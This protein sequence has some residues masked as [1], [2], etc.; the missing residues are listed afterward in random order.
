MAVFPKGSATGGKRIWRSPASQARRRWLIAGVIL[1]VIILLWYIYAHRTQQFPGPTNDPLRL[2]GIIAFVLV[3]ATA[4][5]S[6]RR[7]FVRNLPG[8]VQSWLWM[9]T[10]IGI[11]TILIAVLHEDFVRITHDY[12]EN[13]TCLTDTYYATSALFGLIFLV[14]SG[15]VGRLLDVWQTRVI[16][17]EA[18]SN[19]VGIA[20][21]VEEKILELEY[22]VE[23]LSAGR[24]LPFKQFCEQWLAERRGQRVPPSRPEALPPI[25]RQER[26]QFLQ[27]HRA[28]T[29]RAV[30]LQSLHTQRRARLIMS[31]WR[32]IH[33]ILAT[34]SLLAISYH[35]IME[36]LS[37]VWHIIPAE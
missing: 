37:N 10:W 5:Y 34:I 15:I 1:Y 19:G 13:L 12:C 8:K 3:L 23:R 28:L 7:R 14:V 2:F 36:L 31:T 27:A 22:T 26:E 17:R 29:Q 20:R 11:T 4:S 6:L 16:A 24:S 33:A 25:Q 9:H 30:L 18:S 32:T 35:G 21:S